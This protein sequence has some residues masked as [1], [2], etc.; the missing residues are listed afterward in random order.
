MS[1]NK[2]KYVG[3]LTGAIILG[4][5]PPVAAVSAN[6]TEEVQSQQVVVQQQEKGSVTLQQLVD[7]SN[8]NDKVKNQVINNE[9]AQV[10]KQ[11]NAEGAQTR[12]GKST[13]SKT[14]TNSQVKK[15]YNSSKPYTTLAGFIPKTYG[16]VGL[17]YSNYYGKFEKAAMNGW[18]LKITITSNPNN[19]TSTG[20]TFSVSYVK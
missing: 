15:V 5:F 11:M 2:A 14:L 20:T 8:L 9:L 16:V 17:I 12:V 6:T 4:A 19:P 7:S 3:L 18:G 10:K 13:T 1:L